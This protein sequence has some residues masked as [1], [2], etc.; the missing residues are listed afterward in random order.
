[1]GIPNQY[2]LHDQTTS[3]IKERIA[4]II[5]TS[6]SERL[7]I[8]TCSRIIITDGI[9]EMEMQIGEI[10]LIRITSRSRKV[11][12]PDHTETIKIGSGSLDKFKQTGAF[13]SYLPFAIDS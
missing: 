2:D 6:L 3:Q 10:S 11:F 13:V 12:K 4:I 5:K 1:M 9:T 7:P 8:L